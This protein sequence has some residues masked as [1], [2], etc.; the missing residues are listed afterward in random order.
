MINAVVLSNNIII[1]HVLRVMARSLLFVACS[2]VDNTASI[3]H[4]TVTR[5]KKRITGRPGRDTK[6][7]APSGRYKFLSIGS[8]RISPVISGIA[9]LYPADQRTVSRSGVLS[10]TDVIM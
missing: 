10:D 5:I 9:S 1:I 2:I 7:I 8:S 3:Y 6:T 4:G